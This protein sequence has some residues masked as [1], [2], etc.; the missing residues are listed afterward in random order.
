[1]TTITDRL[2]ALQ[3]LRNLMNPDRPA[4]RQLME[5]ACLEN[6][7]FTMED[8]HYT[9]HHIRQT[10]LDNDLLFEFAAGY[11]LFEKEVNPRK[12]GIVMAGNIPLVGFHDLLCVYLAGHLARVKWSEKDE[13]VF[14][15]IMDEWMGSYPWIS[16]AIQ[17]QTKLNDFQAVIATGSNQTSRY[18]E[19]YFGKYP[20]IIRKN[21]NAV[22]ILD[23]QETI[24]EL[25]GLAEDVL[26]YFGKGCR[27][28]SQIWVPEG[29]AFN[30]L[31][32]ALDQFEDRILHHKYKH[33]YDY[34]LAIHIINRID[35]LVGSQVL[36]IENEQISS[37]IGT[38]H[39]WFYQDNQ[40]LKA[41]AARHREEIQCIVGHSGLPALEL[42]PFGQAQQ[43]GLTTYADGVDVMAFLMQLGRS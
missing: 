24:D 5:K 41:R 12:V 4:L 27:N 36:L 19:E 1:M 10:Y 17:S 6:P 31:I 33:N 28:V 15:G 7:W 35:H 29:Y 40:E 38:L 25:N 26:R 42:V 20:H 23:G 9:I 3:H 11:Q 8:Y 13:I 37:R 34:N 22:A 32:D 30:P 16:N 18:F 43:P 2:Q 21:R 14:P 39:Y